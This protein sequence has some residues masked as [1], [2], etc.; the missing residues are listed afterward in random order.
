MGAIATETVEH[1]G[2]TYRITIY[3]DSDA[4]NPLRDTSQFGT[5]LSLNRRHQNFDTIGIE[6]A[7]NGNPDAVPL[8]YYEHGRC[9]WSVAGELPAM[10]RCRFDSVDLAGV[11]LPEAETLTSARNYGG[12][13]RQQFMR[14]RAGQACEAYTQ[15]CNGEVYGYEIDR[16][17]GCD[18][19]GNDRCEPVDESWGYFGLE[20]CLDE[21]RGSLS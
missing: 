2:L 13:T 10:F 1:D 17:D 18:A 7:M 6:E 12:R 20:H 3:A 21:A 16:V 4:P 11:W 8:S 5:I 19:C 15:W 14:K 9:L